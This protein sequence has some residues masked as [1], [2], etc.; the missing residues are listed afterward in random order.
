MNVAENHSNPLVQGQRL[1]PAP[2]HILKFARKQALFRVD[3]VTGGDQAVED[4]AGVWLILIGQGIER[5]LDMA[6]GAPP[7]V[8]G[9][10]RGDA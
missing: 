5:F 4:A 3:L 9:L 10:V 7:L 2:N 8:A 1:Q 6:M